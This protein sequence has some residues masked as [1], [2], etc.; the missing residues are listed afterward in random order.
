M[1]ERPVKPL[2]RFPY[3]KGDTGYT[4]LLTGER[5]PKY[6]LIPESYGTV[7]EATSFLGLAR[8]LAGTERTR[9]VLL[10]IQEDLYLLMAEL[11]TP[12]EK[13]A[14]SP[15]HITAE[16][17]AWLEQ[18]IEDLMAQTTIPNRFILPGETLPSAALDVART[19]V[20]RAERLVVRLRHRKW[21]AN[22]Q[23]VRYLN[24]LSTLLFILARYEE[25]VRGVPYALAE[26]E[27]GHRL[28]TP[29]VREA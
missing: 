13:Q 6:H 12:P 10:R 3:G 24:R 2:R 28:D 5:V 20:R 19:V 9:A 21:L 4:S 22:E 16:H 7:D 11:A 8:A 25:S 23:V 18:T 1:R 14:A 27:P 17:V 15:Y 26:L 29:P